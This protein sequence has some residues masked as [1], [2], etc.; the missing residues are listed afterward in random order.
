[1]VRQR[2]WVRKIRRV[3]ARNMQDPGS[4]Y[5]RTVQECWQSASIAVEVKKC[6]QSEVLLPPNGL[7]MVYNVYRNTY[8]YNIHIC[9]CICTY[10]IHIHIYICIYVYVYVHTIYIYIYIYTY[11]YWST[12]YEVIDVPIL[13]FQHLILADQHFCSVGFLKSNR[14]ALT[15]VT[16]TFPVW[17]VIF[18]SSLVT[19]ITDVTELTELFLYDSNVLPSHGMA[20]GGWQKVTTRSVWLQ[21]LLG[22]LGHRGTGEMGKPWFGEFLGLSL[23]HV[24]PFGSVSKPYTP[25]EHQNSW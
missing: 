5:W 18:H 20:A 21:W 9:I 2:F 12:I 6:I 4:R 24:I 17:N 14:L 8:I 7:N 3:L 19:N 23:S 13:I 10:N 11:T 25:G 1:M 15:L 22:R 16:L